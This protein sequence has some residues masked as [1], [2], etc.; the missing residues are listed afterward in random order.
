[1]K[2]IFLSVLVSV[3]Q[4]W[5][6]YEIAPDRFVDLMPLQLQS[7]YEDSS[8]QERTNRQYQAYS[9][10]LQYSAFRSELEF[11]QFY[12]KTSSGSVRIENTIREFNLGLGYRVYQLISDD[13]RFTLN[14]FTKL[15]LGQTQTTVATNFG[16]SQST[17]KSDQDM[18]LGASVSVLAR[19]TYFMVEAELRALNSKNMSPQTVPVFG[20][21]LGASIPY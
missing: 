3:S 17:D 7:R 11:N 21:K 19:I 8:G 18:V 13:R 1:M 12:D 15:W 5:A 10:G 16:V 14:A 6:Q 20:L 4:A 9:L 2:I